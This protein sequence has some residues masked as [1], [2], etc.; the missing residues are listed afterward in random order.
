VLAIVPHWNDEFVDR[1]LRRTLTDDW[2]NMSP[3]YRLGEREALV[4][5][6]ELPPPARYFGIQTNV[7][8]REA[9][10]NPNDPVYRLLNEHPRLKELQAIVFESSPNPSRRMLVASI[11]NSTNNVVIEQQ[12]KENWGQQRFF[13]I[14]PDEAMAAAMTNALAGVDGIEASQVFTE[15]V[16]PKLV[17]VGYGHQADDLI[18]Y[19]RYAMPND[20]ALGEQWRQQLPLTILRVRDKKGAMP[21][22]RSI[23]RNTRNG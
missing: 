6:A 7:F 1:S 15:P 5:L 12:S 18:T 19:I 3:N 13:V 20:N 17:R 23:S 9:Q 22:D 2:G 4:V 10:L 11:G 14:T 16:S 21:G 8:T